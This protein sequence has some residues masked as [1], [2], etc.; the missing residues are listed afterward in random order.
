MSD[1]REHLSVERHRARQAALQ[2]LYLQEVG[3]I[4]AA[5][6]EE[7]SEAYWESHPA[8]EERR[9]FADALVAGTMAHLEAI[10]PLL[11][12]SADNWRLSRMAVVDRLIMRLA[13]YELMYSGT[14]AAVV[15]NEA[16]E[17]AKTFGGDKTVRFVNGVLDSINRSLAPR[18]TTP[19]PGVSNARTRG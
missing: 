13:T 8:P 5:A 7:A 1:P 3:R 11:E 14:P 6:S 16:L 18:A 4:D 2:L 17:L 15:I 9:A 19:R 10:D 12:S